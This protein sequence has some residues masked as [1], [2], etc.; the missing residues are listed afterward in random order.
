M[1]LSDVFNMKSKEGRYLTYIIYQYDKIVISTY[2]GLF[3][4]REGNLEVLLNEEFCE[5]RNY[6]DKQMRLIDDFVNTID[7]DN[8][9]DKKLT[10]LSDLV[11][12]MSVY[13]EYVK[14]KFDPKKEELPF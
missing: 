4:N 11:N 6:V 8:L 7:L 1:K 10:E 12:S 5:A 9:D 2:V 13:I 14:D 3:M